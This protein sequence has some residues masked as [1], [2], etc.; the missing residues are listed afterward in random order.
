MLHSRQDTFA[1]LPGSR[2]ALESA[3][4]G[5][6]QGG[7]LHEAVVVARSAV[8]PPGSVGRPPLDAC[9]MPQQ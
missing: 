9:R 3:L 5:L 2:N 6:L 4:T 8:V 7:I 1:G